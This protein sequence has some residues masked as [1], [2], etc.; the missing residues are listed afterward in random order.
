MAGCYQSKQEWKEP[1]NGRELKSYERHRVR[2]LILAQ[3][4]EGQERSQVEL[5]GLPRMGQEPQGDL[6]SSAF[7]EHSCKS[8]TASGAVEGAAPA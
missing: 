8:P 2:K 4:Q 6:G 5:G 1:E 7:Q 3:R